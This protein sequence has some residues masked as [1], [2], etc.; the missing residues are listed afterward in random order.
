MSSTARASNGEVVTRPAPAEGAASALLAELFDHAPL[1]PPAS[2][3]MDAALAEHELA[4]RGDYRWML[5]GF[6]VAASRMGELRDATAG[7]RHPPPRLAVVATASAD[8]SDLAQD[9]HGFTVD[10][11][12][13]LAPDGEFK[14]HA[15]HLRALVDATRARFGFLELPLG[16][17]DADAIQAG[18][19]AAHGAG[20][21]VKV[22]CGGEHAA[23]VP[24]PAALAGVIAACA[25]AGVPMKATA[26][27][28]HPFRHPDPG[29]G[30][31]AHGFVN[32]AAAALLAG[33]RDLGEPAVAEVLADDAGVGAFTFDRDRLRWRDLELTAD[34][35]AAGRRSVFVSIGS[36]SF[37]EPVEDLVALGILPAS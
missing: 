16:S 18:V 5:G 13:M 15:T 27:L 12:E 28:H 31:M 14:R 25:N 26:G 11:V 32:V 21:G 6:V 30:W 33:L 19:L 1:F 4:L 35:I 9:A 7:R 20:V 24:A 22:R 17:L 37:S 23:Q 2:L 3:S 10:L 8:A 36:C 34:E 29:G